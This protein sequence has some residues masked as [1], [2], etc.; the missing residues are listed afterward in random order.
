MQVVSIS[1]LVLA[2]LAKQLPLAGVMGGLIMHVVVSFGGIAIMVATALV[3][4]WYKAVERGPRPP[5]MKP[6]F[7]GGS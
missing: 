4:S 2:S 6:G 1:L 7:A 3:L 5:S